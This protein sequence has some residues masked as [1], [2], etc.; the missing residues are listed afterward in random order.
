MFDWLFTVST[1]ASGSS[2]CR[3]PSAFLAQSFTQLSL[4]VWHLHIFTTNLHF[5]FFH[6]C[7]WVL[8]L[9]LQPATHTVTYSWKWCSAG[10]VIQQEWRIK[11]PSVNNIYLLT[12]FQR[13]IKNLETFTQNNRLFSND[14]LGARRLFWHD[15][16]WTA[17]SKWTMVMW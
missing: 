12:F 15:N 7:D 13:E 5:S 1:W 14:S 9:G 11:F 6:Q 3:N 17:Y 2:V 8:L 16:I 10:H 4:P